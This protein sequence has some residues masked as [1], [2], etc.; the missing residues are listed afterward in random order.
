M[1]FDSCLP[2]AF[3]KPARSHT[4]SEFSALWITPHPPHTVLLLLILPLV[5]CSSNHICKIILLYNICNIKLLFYASASCFIDLP[6]SINS[7]G[8]LLQHFTLFPYFS[9]VYWYSLSNYSPHYFHTL[10]NEYD[11]LLQIYTII[12]LMCWYS[13]K[14]F[15]MCQKYILPT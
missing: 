15:S 4:L 1:Y 10:C 7:F 2:L 14:L 9:H 11:N 6:I 3:Y 5:S 13:L 8:S 12:F